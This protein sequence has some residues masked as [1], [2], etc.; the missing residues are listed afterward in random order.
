MISN[1]KTPDKISLLCLAALVIPGMGIAEDVTNDESTEEKSA[2]DR[3]IEAERRTRL[4]PFVLTP[5]KPNYVLPVTYNET[6]NNAPFDPVT[7]G[8][9]DNYEIKFQISVKFPIVDDP[10]GKQGSLQFA[11]TNLS[12]W[13]AY[14]RDSSSPFRE[15]VHEPEL[16]LVLENNWEFSGFKNR[17]IVLGINHQSNGQSDTSSRS[18]NRIYADFIFERG[19]YYLSFKPWIRVGEL[20][21]DDN[22]DIE[23]Y[24]GH[25]EFRAMYAGSKHKLSVMLRNNFHSPNYG[26]IEIDWSFPMSRRAK[27]F[28]QYFNGYG[29]SLIDYNAPVN[30]LGIG[31][32]LT[33]WL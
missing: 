12:F 25:G 2:L 18:W 30:R 16:F 20:D 11:Y 28:V 26:A 7:D 8:E 22:P 10:F 29:E 9:L 5:H 31:I 14:N 17:L 24:M 33:D 6:P 21:E 27:W 15:T 3:R 4:Q 23:T 32:A 1:M 13:Q 19:K